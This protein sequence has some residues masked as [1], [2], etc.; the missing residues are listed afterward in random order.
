MLNEVQA[1]EDA[2]VDELLGSMEPEP[3]VVESG[4]STT[5][6]QFVLADDVG[7]EGATVTAAEA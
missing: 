4:T 6:A 3:M 7:V 1:V 5:V 2:L